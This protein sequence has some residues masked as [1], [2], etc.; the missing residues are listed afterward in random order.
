VHNENVEYRR[1]FLRHRR[2]ASIILIVALLVVAVAMRGLVR[3]RI[4]QAGHRATSAAMSAFYAAV[5][6]PAALSALDN[7]IRSDPRNSELYNLRG[8]TYEGLGR[9]DEAEK[10]FVAA[11]RFDPRNASAWH[12]LIALQDWRGS[13]NG[14]ATATTYEQRVVNGARTDALYHRNLARLLDAAGERDRAEREFREAV[15]LAPSEGSYY[16]EFS[17]YLQQRGGEGRAVAIGVLKDALAHNASDRG[18]LTAALGRLAF[19]QQDYRLAAEAYEDASR[20]SPHIP[21]YRE[22]AQESRRRVQNR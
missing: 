10:N 1:H 11:T 4:H 14:A 2:A 20:L 6:G 7:A 19:T 13:A 9:F 5:D 18:S 22:M 12:N 21:E 17:D 3:S 8:A 16:L 15:S